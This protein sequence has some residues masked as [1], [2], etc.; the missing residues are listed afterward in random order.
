[1]R[2]PSLHLGAQVATPLDQVA[3]SC[4]T[5]VDKIVC[6]LLLQPRQSEIPRVMCVRGGV[7]HTRPSCISTR[8]PLAWHILVLRAVGFSLLHPMGRGFDLSKCA[9][10]C[11]PSFYNE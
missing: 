8:F 9:F 5:L 6:V 4:D 7:S 2:A 11:T 3:Q 1:M 10:A